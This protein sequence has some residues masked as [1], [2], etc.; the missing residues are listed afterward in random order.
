MNEARERKERQRHGRLLADLLA[1]K[2]VELLAT[3]PVWVERFES[4]PYSSFEEEYKHAWVDDEVDHEGLQLGNGLEYFSFVFV[5]CP[6]GLFD[7]DEDAGLFEDIKV[8]VPRVNRGTKIRCRWDG[9]NEL[10]F[11]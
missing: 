8:V 5:E 1:G 6:V 3:S 11:A 9:D 4:H 2:P 10:L 7:K